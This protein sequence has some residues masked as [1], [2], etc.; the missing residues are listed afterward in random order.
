MVKVMSWNVAVPQIAS[1]FG[2]YCFFTD[3]EL[4][5]EIFLLDEGKSLKIEIVG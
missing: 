4:N 3:D 5:Q 1:S 2:N